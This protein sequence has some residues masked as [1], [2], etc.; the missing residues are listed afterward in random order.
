MARP[1]INDP[2]YIR[3]EYE[4]FED[5]GGPAVPNLHFTDAGGQYLCVVGMPGVQHGMPG[6]Y[7][8]NCAVPRHLFNTGQVCVGIALT[9]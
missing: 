6:R 9:S 8:A 7:M 4:I 3:M 2:I 5:T 1:D